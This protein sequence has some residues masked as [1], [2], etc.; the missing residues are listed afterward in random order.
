M[1]KKSVGVCG[2]SPNLGNRRRQ[3]NSLVQ[4]E[5]FLLNYDYS[6]DYTGVYF[7]EMVSQIKAQRAKPAI[8]RFL[9]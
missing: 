2:K 5:N 1:Q 6:P 3:W 9:G 7:T 4:R 8:R